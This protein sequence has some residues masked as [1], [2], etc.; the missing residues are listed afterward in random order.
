LVNDVVVNGVA[1]GNAVGKLRFA[2]YINGIVPR[3]VAVEAMRFIVTHAMDLVV[4]PAGAENVMVFCWMAFTAPVAF[5]CISG[6]RAVVGNV[7][8]LVASATLSEQGVGDPF[9][10][11]DWLAEHCQMSLLH[12]LGGG[13]ILVNECERNGGCISCDELWPPDPGQGQDKV[14]FGTDRVVNDFFKQLVICVHHVV[15]WVRDWGPMGR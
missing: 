14:K 5:D 10:E 8:Q 7:A 9:H 2:A 15:V 12:C 1:R 4:I 11:G 6:Q 3:L 13:T